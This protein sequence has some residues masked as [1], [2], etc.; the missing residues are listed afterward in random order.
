MSEPIEIQAAVIGL[1]PAGVTSAIYLSRMGI[2][3][4]CFEG[5]RVG[6]HLLRLFEIDDYAGFYGSGEALSR[7]FEK[8]LFDNGVEIV[9]ED[10]LSLHRGSDG[11]LALKTASSSY[12]PKTVVIAAGL[13]PRKASFPAGI[14]VSSNPVEGV[15]DLSGKK[16]A[17]LGGGKEAFQAAKY[18]AKRAT[19]VTLISESVEAPAVLAEE[20]K[21]LSNVVLLSG[22]SEKIPSDASVVY[23][24]PPASRMRGNTAF[25]RLSEIKDDQG[26]IAIGS[27][28]QSFVKGVFA[29]GDVVQKSLKNISTAVSDGA[30]CGVMIYRAL[31]GVD[32]VS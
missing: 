17:V 20:V 9:E 8:Q 3:P 2:P 29:A 19:S 10:V 28:C 18:L 31:T 32:F 7:A 27:D 22:G 1:G 13:T 5:G 24:L 25:C 23:D 12:I 30:L 6:G 14:P 26:N 16:V 15:E 21:G 4:V 11:R